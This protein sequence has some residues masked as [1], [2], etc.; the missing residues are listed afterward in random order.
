LF[1]LIGKVSSLPLT[2]KL[3]ASLIPKKICKETKVLVACFRF[4]VPR[5]KES[6]DFPGKRSGKLDGKVAVQL[7]V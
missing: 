3:T 6:G 1:Y 2:A 7:N 5:D 4:N